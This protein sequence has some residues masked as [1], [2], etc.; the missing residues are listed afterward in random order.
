MRPRWIFKVLNV[1]VFAAL[2]ASLA[3][4]TVS[5]ALIIELLD[6]FMVHKI[7]LR[8]NGI[9]LI[10]LGLPY[11]W[12][13]MLA[14]VLPIA[15]AEFLRTKN[16][17]RYRL[18]HIALVFLVVVAVFGW[19]FYVLGFSEALE[20][21]LENKLPAYTNLIKTQG[22]FWSQP[23]EGLLSGTVVSEDK[24]NNRL[25]LKDSRDIIW[26]VDYYEAKINSKVEMNDGEKIKVLGTKEE[27]HRFKAEEIRPWSKKRPGKKP[28]S[29]I[30]GQ[31]ERVEFDD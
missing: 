4:G 15:I 7:V 8:Q 30:P 9:K 12:L 17:Y 1:G 23:E 5:L 24:A 16:G 19:W 14:A 31:R 10:L 3:I 21:Y 28:I 26:D 18:R 13:I 27:N 11:A 29:A 6:E 22:T 25:E 2:V 20:G